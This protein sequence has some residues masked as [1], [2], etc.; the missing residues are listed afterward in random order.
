MK[1]KRL[2]EIWRSIDGPKPCV[3]PDCCRRR[4]CRAGVRTWLI[5]WN[6]RNGFDFRGV[7]LDEDLELEQDFDML[8]L[9]AAAERLRGDEVI[10]FS[11]VKT[12]GWMR[13]EIVDGGS[14]D[15]RTGEEAP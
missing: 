1:K 10:V 2:R 8:N 4:D 15:L 14:V 3:D 13:G 9:D 6:D 7:D 11:R 5:H 12:Y